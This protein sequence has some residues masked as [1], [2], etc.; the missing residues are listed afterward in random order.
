LRTH[1]QKLGVSPTAS[2]QEIKRAFRSLAKKWH[3]DVN[4][5][6]NAGAMFRAVYESFEIL[7]APE[8]R[9]VYDA[10]LAA[11]ANASR[12]QVPAPPNYA[13]WT[14]SAKKQADEYAAM[15]FDRFSD[16]LGEIFATAYIMT[17]RV[18]VIVFAILYVAIPLFALYLVL[19]F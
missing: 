4:K 14:E 12:E 10:L 19:T 18:S 3:P 8:K 17:L 9:E 2:Q 5:S 6:P 7:S 13:E 1:Y 15:S 11:T 16:K